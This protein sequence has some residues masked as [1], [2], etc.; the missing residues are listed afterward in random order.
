MFFT[1]GEAGVAAVCVSFCFTCSC[2]LSHFVSRDHLNQK[3]LAAVRW[4]PRRG[5]C[6]LAA[7]FVQF[8]YLTSVSVATAPF[9]LKPQW[10]IHAHASSCLFRLCFCPVAQISTISVVRCTSSSFGFPCRCVSRRSG[11]L[12]P[13]S[14]TCPS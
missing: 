14:A 7:S 10:K 11:G 1:R 2:F 3:S 8:S 12:G 6:C 9:R 4:L 5:R 13:K